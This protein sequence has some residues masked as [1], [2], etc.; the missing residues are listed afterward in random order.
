VLRAL[1]AAYGRAGALRF[2][3]T[4]FDP[5]RWSMLRTDCFGVG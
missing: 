4:Y 5:R 3:R 2:C 1:A